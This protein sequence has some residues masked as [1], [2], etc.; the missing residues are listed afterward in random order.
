MVGACQE[1]H[2][3]L[4]TEIT[5]EKISDF[6]ESETHDIKIPTPTGWEEELQSF[7][8]LGSDFAR[9]VR[10]PS[11]EQPAMQPRGQTSGIASVPA[12]ALR[13]SRRRC[14]SQV[15]SASSET[16]E[17]LADPNFRM[18]EVSMEKRDVTCTFPPAP[19]V[20]I[21][22][23]SASVSPPSPLSPRAPP[24]CSDSV[25][26]RTRLPPRPPPPSPP[27]LP[28]PLSP[29]NRYVMENTL[30]S[31]LPSFDT[32]VEIYEHQMDAF[33]R[34]TTILTLVSCALTSMV[35]V[36]IAINVLRARAQLLQVCAQ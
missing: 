11:V 32:A 29:P 13:A 15:A 24:L 23:H 26:P 22:A 12:D 1:D 36:A 28:L 7:R 5:T 9:R 35:V 16:P 21:P 20:V 18:A 10:G 8:E 19:L 33:G 3:K 4:Y 34:L 2:F 30:R 14:C 31:V 25:R 6:Y 27:A 17:N